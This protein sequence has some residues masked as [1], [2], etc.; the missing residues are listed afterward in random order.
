MSWNLSP[1]WEEQGARGLE[2]EGYRKERKL[3]SPRQTA[4]TNSQYRRLT[5]GERR[6]LENRLNQGMSFLE[7]QGRNLHTL[8]KNIY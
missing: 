1:A 3:P 6:D 5:T 8:S 4:R 2:S 7:Y